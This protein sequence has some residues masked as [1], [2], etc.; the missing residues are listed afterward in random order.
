MLETRTAPYGALLLRVL[1]GVPFLAHVGVKLFVFTVPGFVGYFG[2]LGLPPV[3]AYLTIALELFGGL[4]LIFGVYARWVAVPL[5][6]ELLGTIAMVHSKVGWEFNDKG[7]GWEYPAFWATA[8]LVL[9]L[10]G[11]GAHALRPSRPIR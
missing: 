10:L 7:G 9:M 11:D 8:L 6:F 4:A 1:L 3:L 2:S 5:F